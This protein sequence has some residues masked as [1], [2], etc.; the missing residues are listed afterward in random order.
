MLQK[1]KC[2]VCNED[3]DIVM[4]SPKSIHFKIC[5]D[6]YNEFDTKNAKDYGRPQVKK[7]FG[8]HKPL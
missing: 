8:T 1:R 7:E 4:T 2:N 3:K 6:C 5:L